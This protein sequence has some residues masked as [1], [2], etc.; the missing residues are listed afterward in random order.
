MPA[1]SLSPA[2]RVA[3]VM[4][5]PLT[6]AVFLAVAP[7]LVVTACATNSE[8]IKAFFA[9]D[10]RTADDTMLQDAMW[11]LG[12]GVQNLDDTFKA[13]GLAEAD[14]HTQVM[15]N[16]EMMADAAA[17]ANKPGRRQGHQNVAM[18]IDRL[19]IE[20]DA[21]KTAAQAHD[22]SLAQALPASCLAC[23]EGGGGGAQKQATP[24]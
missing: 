17:A 4:R 13:E 12:R 6:L 5:T 24:S 2:V 8:S 9:P 23:H 19:V 16:L 18:N 3:L 1:V 21:A 22:Y 10:F 7:T 11:R 15:E 14:R 20:I